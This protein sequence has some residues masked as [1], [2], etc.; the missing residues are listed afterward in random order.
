MAARLTKPVAVAWAK[1]VPTRDQHE[2][3]QHGGEAAAQ[4]QRQAG[5]AMANDAHSVGRV[6]KR[7]TTRPASG[8]VTIDG[9]KTK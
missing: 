1:N 8:V 6:P 2:A 9:R 4:Q 5:A 3:E 7:A